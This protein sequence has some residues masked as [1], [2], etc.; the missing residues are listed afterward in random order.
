MLKAHLVKPKLLAL[1]GSLRSASL[2]TALLR[3]AQELD[4]AFEWQYANIADVPLYND[5]LDPEQSSVLRLKSQIKA[6]DALLIATPEYNYSVPGVLKNAIDWASRPGYRSVFVGKP[7][8]IMGASASSVGT[9][10][11]QGHLRQVLASVLAQVFAHPDF[12]VA[13]AS[14]RFHDGKLTHD[15]TRK[16]LASYLA[17]F[18]HWA[19]HAAENSTAEKA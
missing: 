19:R 2:N 9:A 3:A 10:R 4:H 14:E 1:S 15:Q 5:D 12:L 17:A 8:A 11:A 13:Q 18:A 16:Q 6:A 7:V